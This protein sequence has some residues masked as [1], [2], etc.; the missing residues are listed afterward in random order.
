MTRDV[1]TQDLNYN[2][3]D[4]LVATEPKADYRILYSSGEKFDEIKKETLP[5]IFNTGDVLV[6]NDTRVMKRRIFTEEG[7]E[8]LFL[9]PTTKSNGNSRSEWHVLF[10]ARDLKMGAELLLPQNVK[11]KLTAKGLPQTLQVIEGE[12]NEEYFSKNAFLALPPYIQK[13]R[14]ERTPTNADDKWYQTA[15]AENAGSLAAPTASLHFTEEDLKKIESR[16]V[17]I[18]RLTLH[19]GIGT[20]LPIKVE[21]L[22]EHKMHQE[23]AEISGKTIQ[24]IEN[25]KRDGHRIWGLGT[26]VVRSL[27]SWAENKLVWNKDTQTASGY[28]DL[29]IQPG[30]KFKII[31]GILTNFHQPGSS[32]I[33]LV[34]AFAGLENV[35]KAYSYAIEHRFRLFSYG[36]LSIWT[37]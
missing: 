13:A 29:F 34:A 23:W 35:Q 7:L 8:I 22:N 28:T 37:K 10:P 15:W 16:G 6:I 27:E 30:Y 11:L 19:V 25:A 4:D 5:H 18:V 2:Y 14:G 36:D 20:F 9:N 21:D 31:D 24:V 33:A 3:P 12:L 26:T 17:H 32:L 1:K